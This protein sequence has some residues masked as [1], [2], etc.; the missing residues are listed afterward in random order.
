LKRGATTDV[1]KIILDDKSFEKVN[2]SQSSS[3]FG[4]NAHKDNTNQ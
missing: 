2:N 4:T 3:V 1:K